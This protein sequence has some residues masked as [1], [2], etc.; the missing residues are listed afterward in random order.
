[1]GKFNKKRAGRD[2]P[3]GGN[4]GGGKKGRGRSDS[5]DGGRKNLKVER[6]D[7]SKGIKKGGDGNPRKISL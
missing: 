3:K 2:T 1:M 5:K 4:S 6:R 7:G